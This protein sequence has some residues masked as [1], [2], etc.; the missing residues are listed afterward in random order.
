MTLFLILFSHTGDIHI[1]NRFFGAFYVLL[2]AG[3]IAALF[4]IF[5][6]SVMQQQ[7]EIMQ[8]RFVDVANSMTKMASDTANRVRRY[9]RKKLQ[10]YYE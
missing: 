2:G 5:S 8:K 10:Q 6:N 9:Q 1:R 7:E 4:S 3:I